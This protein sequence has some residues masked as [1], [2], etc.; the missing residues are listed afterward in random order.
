M[1]TKGMKYT[2]QYSHI[3]SLSSAILYGGLIYWLCNQVDF[4]YFL[5]LVPQKSASCILKMLQ[6]YEFVK[7]L[8]F[9][10]SI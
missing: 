1:H 2:R 4:V 6:E 8:Y 9:L 5:V 7:I 10:S 3:S